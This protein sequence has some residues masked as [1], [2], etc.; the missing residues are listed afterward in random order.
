MSATRKPI[1]SLVLP[2]VIL[3]A[4]NLAAS[5]YIVPIFLQ[6][7]LNTC[8]VVYMGCI[9]STRLFKDKDQKLVNYSKSLED[10]EAVIGMSEAKQFPFVASAF[11][12]GIYLLYKFLPKEV[13]MGIINVYFSTTIVMSISALLTEVL[14]YPESMRKVIFS[15]DIPKI[16]QDML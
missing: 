8:T 15:I 14:P 3:L 10:N 5:Q 2:A 7:L 6:L 1:R 9:L 13:F 16:L 12:F 4:T 11:L